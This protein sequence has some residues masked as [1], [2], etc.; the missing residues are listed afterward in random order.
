MVATFKRHGIR[1]LY[2]DNW[3]LQEDNPQPQL[4]C[5][6]LQS[7]GSSFWMLQITET[8]ES[9]PKL[10]TEALESVR[11]DYE[12]VDASTAEEDVEGITLAGYDLQFYCLDFL[13]SARIRSFSLG[14]RA[15]V[16][17][18]Q[19]EDA[20]FEKNAPVF[21]AITTSLIQAA[22]AKQ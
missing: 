17:L 6:T 5:V 4:H 20:E 11:Q 15:C 19:A 13:I 21:S 16:L 14:D 8:P 7:P 3:E 1:F 18:S 2:P 22:S 10:A 12:N 9:L